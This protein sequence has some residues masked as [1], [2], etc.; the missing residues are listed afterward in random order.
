MNGYGGFIKEYRI[1][2]FTF[3]SQDLREKEKYLQIWKVIA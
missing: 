2:G 1:R 3:Q